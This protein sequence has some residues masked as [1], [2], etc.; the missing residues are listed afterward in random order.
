MGCPRN[1]VNSKAHRQNLPTL[2]ARLLHLE[3]YFGARRMASLKG[4]DIASYRTK[5]QAEGSGPSGINRE[6][7]ALA[8]AFSLG[9]EL[10]LLNESTLN[11]RK[12]HVAENPPRSGFFEASQYEAVMRHLTHIVVRVVDGKR[13]KI[14]VPADDL[15]LAC[16]IAYRLGWRK[17]EILMLERRQTSLDA[18]D[19][20]GTLCLDPGSTKNDEGRYVVLPPDLKAAIAA[21]LQRLDTYQRQSGRITKYLFTHTVGLHAGSRI[22]DFRRVWATACKAAGVPAA[23]FHDF[24]RTAVRGMVNATVPERVAM[25]ITGHKTR[26]VFDRYHIVA[27]GDLQRAAQLM[28]TANQQSDGVTQRGSQA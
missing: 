22:R 12:Y 4:A 25:K 14:K 18:A 7:S 3:P 13:R 5:R 16:L 15:K 6:L 26:S 9:R 24:R 23:I 2:R 17:N 11:V 20:M 8:R 21:Q 10:E 19:G 28:A 27:N 1:R